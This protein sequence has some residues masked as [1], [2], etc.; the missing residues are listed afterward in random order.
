MPNRGRG[1]KALIFNG[2][3]IIELTLFNGS[4]GD[5]SFKLFN[6]ERADLEFTVTVG[7]ETV[8][9]VL[10]GGLVVTGVVLTVERV[11]KAEL[12]PG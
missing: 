8:V 7:R 12:F 11:I 10:E 4:R 5:E 3:V 6:K 9:L 1:V 2:S